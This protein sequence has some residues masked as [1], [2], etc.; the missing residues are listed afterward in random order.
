MNM[1]RIC[2]LLSVSLLLSS[3]DQ[4]AGSKR[5]EPIDAPSP[6]HPAMSSTTIDTGGG[7]SR[8]NPHGGLP[9]GHPPIDSSSAPPP[10]SPPSGED[11]GGSVQAST[12]STSQALP[13]GPLTI[14]RF[15]FEVA[16]G[17]VRE[18][19]KSQMRK[20]QFRLPRVGDD[21]ED[22][23]MSVIVASGSVDDNID[24]WRKQFVENPPADRS[25]YEPG[26]TKVTT[27]RIAG[28]F[29]ASRGPFAGGGTPKKDFRL[30]AAIVDMGGGSSLFF[31]AVGPRATIASFEDRLEA[32]ASGLTVQ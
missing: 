30:W 31:K 32:M 19:P 27:V 6:K 28:T 24:R 29:T 26:G 1:T 10:A 15:T 23:E 16:D 12:P 14:G 17:L 7:H 22:G 20:A 8:V 21:Q 9:A 18:V 5:N 25:S 13:D 4:P 3:C 2:F 11:S